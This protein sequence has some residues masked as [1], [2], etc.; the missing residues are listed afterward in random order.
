VAD[1]REELAPLDSEGDVA[2]DTDLSRPTRIGEELGDVIDRE[3]SH[4]P[5]S[6]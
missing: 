4:G 5:Q 6:E 1:H 2:E 3:E